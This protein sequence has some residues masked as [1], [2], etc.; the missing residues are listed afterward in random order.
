[1]PKLAKN[2]YK[3]LKTGERRLNC[4]VIN[5]PKEVVDKTDIKDNEVRIYA[6]DKKIIIEKR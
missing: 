5:I 1:M 4:Y 6:K 3:S 2:M